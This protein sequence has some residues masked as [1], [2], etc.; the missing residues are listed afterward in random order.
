[1]LTFISV[2]RNAPHLQTQAVLFPI[3]SAVTWMPS[4]VKW[5]GFALEFCWQAIDCGEIFWVKTTLATQSGHKYKN[6]SNYIV[7]ASLLYYYIGLFLHHSFHLV[8][9]QDL[10]E[11]QIE[12][13]LISLEI[14][15]LTCWSLSHWCY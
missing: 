3:T 10:F 11:L 1:M 8:V 13:L 6:I 4:L 15:T 2:I 5:E 12:T 7:T 9:S 14:Q